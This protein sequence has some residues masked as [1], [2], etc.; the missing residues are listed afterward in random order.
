MEYS[1]FHHNFP[2]KGK[3]KIPLD[4]ATQHFYILESVRPTAAS[5]CGGGG[6]ETLPPDTNPMFTSRFF[7]ILCLHHVF[8]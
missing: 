1:E 2:L 6:L 7:L 4:S 5:F 3:K 8:Y